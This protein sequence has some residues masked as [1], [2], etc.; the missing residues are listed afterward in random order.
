M[1]RDVFQGGVLSS[2]IMDISFVVIY[3]E[4]SGLGILLLLGFIVIRVFMTIMFP[5]YNFRAFLN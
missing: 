5:V 2:P 4:Q 3:Q 1:G